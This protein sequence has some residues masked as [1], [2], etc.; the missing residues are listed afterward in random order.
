LEGKCLNHLTNAIEYYSFAE[1]VLI[2]YQLLKR[3]ASCGIETKYERFLPHLGH[4]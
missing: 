4:S 2:N 1:S 3:G